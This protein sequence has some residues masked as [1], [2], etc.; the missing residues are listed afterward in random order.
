MLVSDFKRS[1]EVDQIDSIPT[2]P[3]VD[4]LASAPPAPSRVEDLT[5]IKIRRFELEI[6]V[7]KSMAQ[8]LEECLDQEVQLLANNRVELTEEREKIKEGMAM[9]EAELKTLRSRILKLNLEISQ[10]LEFSYRSFSL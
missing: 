8:H 4:A 3:V 6:S 10:I 2:P 1:A 5:E 7:L 9:K